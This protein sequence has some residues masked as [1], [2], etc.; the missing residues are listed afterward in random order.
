MNVAVFNVPARFVFTTKD[1]VFQCQPDADHGAL[2]AASARGKPTVSNDNFNLRQLILVRQLP[3]EL[4]ET[5]VADD[6]RQLAV[7][8]HTLDAKVLDDD[9]AVRS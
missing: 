5:H 2:A 4:T 8:Q 9:A 7:S 1:A 6:P 3:P